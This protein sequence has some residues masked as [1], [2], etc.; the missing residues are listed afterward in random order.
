MRAYG[1]VSPM[2]WTR[3]SGKRLRG[4]KAAQLVALYLMTSPHT[5]MVG[6][7]HL[8]LP[9]LCHE[10]GLTLEEARKGLERCYEEQLAFWDEVEELVFVP[11]LA[12]HQ[13]GETL[14]KTDH[15]V[16]GVVRALAPYKGHRFY[17]LFLERYADSY[18]LDEAASKSLPRDDVPDPAPVPVPVRP[19][20]G[21]GSEKPESLEPARA[22]ARPET[23]PPPA[24][25]AIPA[26]RADRPPTNREE[27]EK[28]GACA[29]A[30]YLLSHPNAAAYLEPQRWKA[31]VEVSDALSHAS[32]R[33]EQRR[34]L[35]YEQ[36]PGVR[37][38]IGLLAAGYLPS[39]LVQVAKSLPTR[40]W[41]RKDGRTRGLSSM[42]VEVVDR[43]LAELNESRSGPGL[44]TAAR[45]LLKAA[46]FEPKVCP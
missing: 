37:A 1:S 27:A 16:K 19:V 14:K 41:W 24:A 15:K 11:A 12:H 7:F 32:G 21:S 25:A 38:V 23:A 31:V 4:D 34:L 18:S 44:S 5:T 3:G 28:L 8:S 26:A 13:L 40:D 20:S 17:D 36:D 30:E 46:G 2:F 9:S 39:T 45:D 10:T 29:A 22:P 35:S 43:E 42:T 6:I 33:S